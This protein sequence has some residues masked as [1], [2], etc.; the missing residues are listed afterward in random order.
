M[1]RY[2]SLG[3]KIKELRKEKGW[4]QREL[5]M[6]IHVSE[7]SVSMYERGENEPS[8]A[9]LKALAREFGVTVDEL[10][11]HEAW[12]TMNLTDRN[13]LKQIEKVYL[14]YHKK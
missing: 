13:C 3:T 5:G 4:S 2:D 1:A 9:A 10:V 8:I 11:G 14:E 6:R 7:S 12:G